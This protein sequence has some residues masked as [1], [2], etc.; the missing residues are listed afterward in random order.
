MHLQPCCS[1]SLA[2]ELS[3]QHDSRLGVECIAQ[4]ES[5]VVATHAGVEIVGVTKLSTTIT[6]PSRRIT[7]RAED[8]HDMIAL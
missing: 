4:V 1:D 2:I 6:A 5:Q 3:G 8:C 7:S